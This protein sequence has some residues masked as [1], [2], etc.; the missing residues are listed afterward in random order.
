M[1]R[2]QQKFLRGVIYP[3]ILAHCSKGVEADDLHDFFLGECFGWRRLN[4]F[5]LT[6]RKPIRRSAELT[7]AEMTDFIDYIANRCKAEGIELPTMEHT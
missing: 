3:A 5:G 6:K 4:L 7:T 2:Q 1:S